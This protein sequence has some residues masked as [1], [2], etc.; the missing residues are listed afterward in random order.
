MGFYLWYS[1]L[2]ALR[3]LPH[4]ICARLAHDMPWPVSSRNQPS[5]LFTLMFRQLHI[6]GGGECLILIVLRI[7]APTVPSIIFPSSAL[8]IVCLYEPEATLISC[9]FLPLA[10]IRW[11]DYSKILWGFLGPQSRG[12]LIVFHMVHLLLVLVYNTKNHLALLE[13]PLVPYNFPLFLVAW[14]NLGLGDKWRGLH[15]VWS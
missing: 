10:T 15:V 13:Y 12:W 9:D 11:T 2:Q 3:R 1:I 6:K 4:D 14:G 7:H 5:N 8:Q